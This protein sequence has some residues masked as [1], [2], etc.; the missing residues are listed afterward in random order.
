M[1]PTIWDG[2][3]QGQHSILSNSVIICL[4]LI[5]RWVF[6]MAVI[7]LAA[8]LGFCFTLRE[9]RP[10]LLLER[11]VDA[12]RTKLPGKDIK[13]LNPDAAPDFKTLVMVTLLR[14]LRLLS[15]EP[16]VMAVAFMGSV[17]CAL[18][19]LQAE[20]IPLVFQDYGWSTAT[21]SLG[22]IPVLLGCLASSFTRFYDHHHLDMI[23]KSGRSVEPEDKLTG[24]AL[25][26][27]FL[28]GGKSCK[29]VSPTNVDINPR[30]DYGYSLGP[31]P[32]SHKSTGSSP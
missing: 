19:Y 21:A 7:G 26:A 4:P 9:T 25:A 10:S 14:P 1:S 23:I 29:P 6:W 18:F 12:L 27:P 13:T 11:E 5:R 8:L 17:T 16:I 3:S 24:F 32:R 28:A 30:Q 22:F 15:T 20:S 31:P 2:K